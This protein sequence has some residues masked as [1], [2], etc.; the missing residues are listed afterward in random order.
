MGRLY[1]LL[2]LFAFSYPASSQD[3]F[4]FNGYI[5]DS[6]SGETLIGAN[7]NIRSEGKGIVSNQYGF[8]SITLP[9]NNYVVSVSFVG[10][11]SK[12]FSVDLIDNI[13]QNILL[14][15]N[16]AIINNVTVTTRKRD[17][18]IKAAQMGKIELSINHI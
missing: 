16:S 13:Q 14:L 7:L 1:L 12:E 17:N 11:Q 4:T 2:I 8:F 6:L 18:N 10:Y 3:K 9:K 5:K 15:P